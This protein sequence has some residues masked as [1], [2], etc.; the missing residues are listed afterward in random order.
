MT[1]KEKIGFIGGGRMAEALIKGMIQ[2]GLTGGEQ[3]YV[4]DPDQKRR[5]FLHDTY[6]VHVFDKSDPVL[7]AQIIILA[8]KPQI[9]ALVLNEIGEN[10]TGD[11][12]LI[13]IAA[14]IPLSFIESALPDSACRVIRVMP[15]TPA[16]VLAGASA[17][18]PGKKATGEDLDQAA[19]IFDAV[20]KTV[21]MAESSLD[22]VT[23]LSG[24][25][26]AYV[27]SFIEAMID[28]GVKVGLPRNEAETL[29]LQT[30]YGSVKLAMESGE[31]PA[32]LRAMVTSP[33]GTTIAGLH[34]LEKGGFQGMIMD[35]VE[36]ATKRSRELG[37]LS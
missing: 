34:K 30:V 36:A 11:H 33:G 12:L 22:A 31:H 15:N 25:G 20:G 32:V 35:A 5:E 26:P 3:L 28:A 2:A 10:V 4:V 29:V 21:V 7:A 24:S 27:F 19:K 8:V 9:M 16:L 18:S 6:G 1:M 17:L 14:G 37:K 13:S 23:G